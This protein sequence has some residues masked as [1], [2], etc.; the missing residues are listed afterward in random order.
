[1]KDLECEKM[2]VRYN[3]DNFE[4]IIT[5]LEK[6]RED[7]AWKSHIMSVNNPIRL[8]IPD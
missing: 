7:L 6:V 2:L 4:A 3:N 8:R 5:L 1:M